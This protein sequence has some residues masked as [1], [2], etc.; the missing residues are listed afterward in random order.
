MPNP[1][2]PFLRV[3]ESVSKSLGEELFSTLQTLSLTGGMW[4]V[5][6]CS[7]ASSMERAR[8]NIIPWLAGPTFTAR[9]RQAT[10]KFYKGNGT[11]V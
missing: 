1:H 4:R 5:S 10:Y 2:F 11:Y 3:F 7:V 6:H 9:T 8:T